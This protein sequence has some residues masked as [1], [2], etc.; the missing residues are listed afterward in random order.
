MVVLAA[1]ATVDEA[2][3]M[4]FVFAESERAKNKI[5]S[6]RDGLLRGLY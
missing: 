2:A 5:C 4:D 3:A 1:A 6:F